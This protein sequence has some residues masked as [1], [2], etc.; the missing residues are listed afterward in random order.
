ML[1]LKYQLT[2]LNGEVHKRNLSLLKYTLVY[3][4]LVDVLILFFL[5]IFFC[6]IFTN[7]QSRSGHMK[8]HIAKS[9]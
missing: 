8:S 9:S 2:H 3:L 1:L 4:F 5:F 6:R 7:V